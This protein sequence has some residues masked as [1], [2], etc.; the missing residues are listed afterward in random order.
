MLGARMLRRLLALVVFALSSDAIA[1]RAEE[2]EPATEPPTPPAAEAGA[3]TPLVAPPE[4]LSEF[5]REL[6]RPSRRR[7]AVHYQLAMEQLDSYGGMRGSGASENVVTR[8]RLAHVHAPDEPEILFQ[9]ASALADAVA[10]RSRRGADRRVDEAITMF[11]RLRE[12]DPDY[13]AFAV[14]TDLAVLH[15]R[16][17]EFAAAMAEYERAI[18]LAL[19]DAGLGTVLANYAEVSME[20]GDLVGAIERYE[21][22]LDHESRNGQSGHGLALV[23]FGLAVALDRLGESEPAIERA[24]QAV[25]A[26]GGTLEVLT[27]HQVFFEPP[28]ELRYYQ[29]LGELAIARFASTPNERL[30]HLQQALTNVRRFLDEGGANG[31]Y[32][33]VARER[34]RTIEAEIEQ[35]RAA[36]VRPSTTGPQRTARPRR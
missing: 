2:P 29:M 8:L 3:T 22:A 27:S 35:R 36:V 23:A 15:T 16:R 5:Y 33:D 11:A 24:H 17:G 10:P 26:G 12:L 13:E 14:G 25:M 28:E 9:L 31:P 18:P 4:T 30:T 21:R 19:G 7:A 1:A 20:S 34:K 32:A 6:R